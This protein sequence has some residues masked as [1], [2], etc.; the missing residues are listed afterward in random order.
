MLRGSL[1]MS[2]YQVT[3]A[4]SYEEALDRVVRQPHP[5]LAIT[6]L[7]LGTH[8]GWQLLAAL[9]AALPEAALPVIA[10]AR[11]DAARTEMGPAGSALRFD[12]IET[13][14]DR[15][16]LLRTV[17]TILSKGASVSALPEVHDACA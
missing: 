10:V 9:R 3:E 4:A 17:R 15:T 7:D 14:E 8:S 1:E 5:E 16:R 11:E 13:A 2:G 12:S 6:A